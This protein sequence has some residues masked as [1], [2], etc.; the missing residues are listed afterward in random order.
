MG[1]T[2]HLW[3]RLSDNYFSGGM[4]DHISVVSVCSDGEDG[5]FMDLAQSSIFDVR[6]R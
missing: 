6:L 5:L 4:R 1:I 2:I 3:S